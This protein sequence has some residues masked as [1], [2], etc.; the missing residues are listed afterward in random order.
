L[1]ILPTHRL[2]SGLPTVTLAQLKTAL[3][4]EFDIVAEFT[5]AQACWEHIQMDGGQD[6][7]GFGSVADGS[8]LV[9]K[10]RSH[11][12]MVSLAPTQSEEWRS[13]AVSILHKLVIEKLFRDAFNADATCRYVHLLQEV[14][15]AVSQQV[16][17][18]ACLVPPCGMEHVESIAGNLEKMPPKS[19]YFYPK[20]LT[21]LVLHSLKQE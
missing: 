13:L 21:G 6:V 2:L 20:I 17:Q 18:V 4:P 14:N 8:W 12:T 16:C 7:L 9:A 1:L 19:T 5:N 11:A 10:L 3:A 15:E